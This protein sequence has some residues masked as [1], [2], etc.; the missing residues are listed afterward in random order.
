MYKKYFKRFV[1]VFFSVIL[2]I[3]LLPV[4]LII[5]VLIKINMGSPILFTQERVG[6][7]LKLFKIYKFR[8]MKEEG[9]GNNSDIARLTKFGALIRKISFDEFPQIFNILKG[10]MS[11]IGPRPL[12]KKYIPFYN[13]KEIARHIVRPGMTSLAGVNG[14]SNLTWEEQFEYDIKYVDKLTIGMDLYIFL[15]TLHKVLGAKDVM[16]VGR[17]N[18]DSFDIH[19]KRQIENEQIE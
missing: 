18:T 13:K 1:D 19:R 7:N 2:I 17:K 15:Q 11:F 12:L 5:A 4:L 9:N 14:R 6:K 3:V 16:V 8:T 10:D